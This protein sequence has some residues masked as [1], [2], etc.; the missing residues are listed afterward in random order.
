MGSIYDGVFYTP[1]TINAPN[2]KRDN[3]TSTA[4]AYANANISSLYI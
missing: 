3:I 2:A 1:N 4:N